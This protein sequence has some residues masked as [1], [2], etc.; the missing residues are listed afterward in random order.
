M[1]MLQSLLSSGRLGKSDMLTHESSAGLKLAFHLTDHRS[2]LLDKSHEALV[3]GH[4]VS[5]DRTA[6]F[7]RRRNNCALED[8]VKVV[9]CVV[10][11]SVSFDVSSSSMDSSSGS[12]E[13]SSDNMKDMLLLDLSMHESVDGM[14]N[15]SMLGSKNSQLLDDLSNTRSRTMNDR[16][17]GAVDS[18]NR[19]LDLVDLLSVMNGLNL[20][21]VDLVS[22]LSDNVGQMSDLSDDGRSLRSRNSLDSSSE[23]NNLVV[24][25]GDLLDDSSNLVVSL[26]NRLDKLGVTS[27]DRSR[28]QTSLRRSAENVVESLAVSN[29]HGA[30]PGA[31]SSAS[32][33]RALVALFEEIVLVSSES[34]SQNRS[35]LLGSD[36][37][38][39][40]QNSSAVSNGGNVDNSSG[41]EVLDLNLDVSNDSSNSDSLNLGKLS[42]LVGKLNNSGGKMFDVFI[43]SLN[44][45]MFPNNNLAGVGNDGS[46]LNSEDMDWSSNDLSDLNDMNLDLSNNLL[47]LSCDV[48]NSLSE[49]DNSRLDGNLESR[50]SDDLSSQS[51]DGVVDDSSLGGQFDSL[52]SESGDSSSDVNDSS[53][54]RSRAET[55]LGRSSENRASLTRDS[56]GLSALGALSLKSSKLVSKDV[57]VA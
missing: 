22:Q 47:D 42:E 52:S 24:D 16:R 36:V 5:N 20:N 10:D 33:L 41:S 46:L 11:R 23:N 35:Q 25:L 2:F 45:V 1:V 43:N 54:L 3:L 53:S 51:L 48:N 49:L 26:N 17:S 37:V 18:R 30:V 55:H 40:G 38:V 44:F 29:L 56:A 7:S 32:P 21:N 57:A 12:D 4:S 15:L 50:L 14:I 28:L 19:L 9:N 27:S 34:A 13:A 39:F 8:L 6:D 31:S